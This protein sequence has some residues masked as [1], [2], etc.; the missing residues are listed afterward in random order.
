MTFSAPAGSDKLHFEGSTSKR[1][2][3]APGAYT[4]TMLATAHGKH[5]AA[6]TIRFTIV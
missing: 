2:K 3:L 5:S 6:R 1:R 4:L